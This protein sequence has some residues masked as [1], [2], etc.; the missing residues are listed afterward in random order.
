MERELH[1]ESIYG[2]GI[3]EKFMNK[4]CRPQ[5]LAWTRLKIIFFGEHCWKS[6]Y[7]MP[8]H[9]S[10]E[11]VFLRLSKIKYRCQISICK[12]NVIERNRTHA[13]ALSLCDISSFRVEASAP[14]I[15]RKIHRA[16]SEFSY[17]HVK[18]H[19]GVL[20]L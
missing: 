11:G 3:S 6:V 19:F 5:K 16:F 2:H 13:S 18:C 14:L 10:S 8:R 1:R 12:M 20:R 15:T 7:T 9:W 4:I 17:H